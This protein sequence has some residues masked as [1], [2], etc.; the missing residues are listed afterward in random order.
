M[1]PLI[2]NN[3]CIILRGT[4]GN[5]KS[6]FAEF[7]EFL[8]D[9]P[10]DIEICCADDWFAR[11]GEY[12]FD[13]S[14]LGEAHKCCRDKARSVMMHGVKICVIANTNCGEKEFQPYID[15]ARENG[16]EVVS[17]VLENRNGAQNIH[18]VSDFTLAKQKNK[19]LNSLKL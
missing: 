13:A 1:N 5:G 15:M 17:L 2:E 14:K 9:N 19:L 12:K 4:S 8:V 7:L 11:D 10:A 6:T 18:G 3:V 16:Y